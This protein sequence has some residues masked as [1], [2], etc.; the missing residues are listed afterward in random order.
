MWKLKNE[1]TARMFTCEMEAINDDVNKE[2]DVQKNWLL[3]KG[4]WLKGSKLVC[5]MKKNMPQHKQTWWWNR[6]VVAQ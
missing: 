6:I 4:T 3:M 5:G 1:D 2:D